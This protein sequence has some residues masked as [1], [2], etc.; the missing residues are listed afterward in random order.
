MYVKLLVS[1][2]IKGILQDIAGSERDSDLFFYC[3][4]MD[5]Q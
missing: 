4:Y 2:R 3:G 5:S 1:I